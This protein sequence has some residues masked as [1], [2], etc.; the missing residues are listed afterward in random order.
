LGYY[1]SGVYYA[2]KN[3]G[4]IPYQALIAAAGAI[5]P[6]MSSIHDRGE[7]GEFGFY[8]SLTMRYLFFMIVPA[9]L[10]MVVFSDKLL[11]LI[12]SAEYLAGDIALKLLS[13]AFL[14]SVCSSF[15][16]TL[17]MSTGQTKAIVGA[18]NISVVAHLAGC[19]LFVPAQ[20]I[21]GAGISWIIASVILFSALAGVLLYRKGAII[22]WRVLAK[23]LLAILPGVFIFIFAGNFSEYV[24]FAASAIIY[25]LLVHVMK[26]VK[27]QELL[28]IAKAVLKIE[29]D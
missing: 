12:Y 28:D 13:I 1:D 15:L 10:F 3:I 25:L 4:Q 6:T 2:A 24:M 7:D 26:A 23:C 9:A 17:L 8:A 29:T 11:L 16:N 5:F 18:I 20:G 14:V 21:I 19:Y 27:F 22:P